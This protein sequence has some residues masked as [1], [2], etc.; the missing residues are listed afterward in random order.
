MT[1][2]QTKAA[3]GR[4][5]PPAARRGPGPSGHPHT[6]RRHCLQLRSPRLALP[7]RPVQR[8]GPPRSGARPP[9][10][11]SQLATR[12]AGAWVTRAI[13]SA[14]QE[15]CDIVAE[16][17]PTQGDL[18]L[19]SLPCWHQLF[20]KSIS[21]GAQNTGVGAFCHYPP[22]PPPL[23]TCVRSVPD[24]ETEM[25]IGGGRGAERPQGSTSSG[26][27]LPATA[28]PRSCGPAAGALDLSLT[29]RPA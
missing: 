17:V 14:P 5:Q 1:R 7:T 19:T 12:R 21:K 25:S 8:L 22:P 13:L 10:P 27:G 23:R 18:L 6:C 16:P 9:S 2:P 24:T 11:H 4:C 29:Q 28:P 15:A 20:T 3:K 26:P